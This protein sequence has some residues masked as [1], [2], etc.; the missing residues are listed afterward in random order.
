MVTGSRPRALPGLTP[1]GR[2]IPG[3]AL[4]GAGGSHTDEVVAYAKGLGKPI[5][6]LNITHQ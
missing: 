6:R 3:R 4:S 5:D 2:R 1:D